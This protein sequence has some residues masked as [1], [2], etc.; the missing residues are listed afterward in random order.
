MGNT[1]AFSTEEQ[2]NRVCVSKNLIKATVKP[3]ANDEWVQARDDDNHQYWHGI[4]K[5]GGKSPALGT[6]LEELL[7]SLKN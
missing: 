2:Q 4:D 6:V 5:D 3:G 7:I 1:V